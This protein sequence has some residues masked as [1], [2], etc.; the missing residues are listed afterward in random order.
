MRTQA[1][2]KKDWLAALK[3]GSLNSL[4]NLMQNGYIPEAPKA[5]WEVKAMSSEF[6]EDLVAWA[7]EDNRFELSDQLLSFGASSPKPSLVLPENFETVSGYFKQLLVSPAELYLAVRQTP[8][9]LDEVDEQGQTLLHHAAIQS[10]QLYANRKNGALNAILY[11]LIKTSANDL[12]QAD[13]NGVKAI[14][15]LIDHTKEGSLTLWLN[16]GGDRWDKATA[17]QHAIA[18]QKFSSAILLADM[19]ASPKD[20]A[21][22]SELVAQLNINSQRIN[23]AATTRY[24]FFQQCH[25]EYNNLE[26]QV[27]DLAIERGHWMQAFDEKYKGLSAYELI[28]M[29]RTYEQSAYDHLG[30][31]IELLDIQM[32]KLTEL[33]KQSKADEHKDAAELGQIEI[34]DRKINLSRS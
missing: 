34:L 24:A 25:T 9:L 18:K 6:S 11:V 5:K 20:S 3:K 7:V 12:N 17:L 30:Y 1:E 26:T 31:Q 27:H 16:L 32:K 14:Q 2:M 21:A 8:E 33:Y 22:Q 4:T 15:F 19:G 28:S 13:C 10:H 29:P 23:N